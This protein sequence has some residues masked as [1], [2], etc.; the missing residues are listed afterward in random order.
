MTNALENAGA[1][2]GLFVLPA[3]EDYLIQAQGQTIGD[4]VE[5]VLRQTPTPGSRAPT[6]SS[7]MSSARAKA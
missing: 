5:V 4:Q 3:G 7:A 2:R 1:E 6:P